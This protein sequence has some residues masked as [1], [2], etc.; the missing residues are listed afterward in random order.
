MSN[1]FV[2]VVLLSVMLSSAIF[3]SPPSV[4]ATSHEHPSTAMEQIER[5]GDKTTQSKMQTPFSWDRPGPVFA[6]IHLGS[7][8]AAG[9][10]EEPLR[11]IDQVIEQ[12]MRDHV[13]PGAVV[14]IVRRGIIVKH[15]AYGYAK[16]YEDDAFIESKQPIP[17]REDTI[18][19]VASISKLFTATAAMKLYE[20]GKILL[21]DPVAKYIPEF[22]QN[23]KE[24]VTIRQ[25]MTHTSG[26]AAW[27][28][29]YQMGANR[30]E[31]LQIVFAQPLEHPPGT[32]YTYSDLNMI[33]L[34]ALVE[35]LSGLRLDQFVYKYITKP[36]GM[37]DTMYNPSP[38]LKTRIAA[39]EYQPWTGRGLVWGEVHD[40][41]AWALDGVAGHAGVFS[42]AHDLAIFASM[43]LQN[44]K[45]GGK[46][47]LQPETVRLLTEN[48][49]PQF[50]GNDHGLGWELAQGWYMD[51]LSESTTLGHTGYTGTSI[52]VSPNNHVIAILLTNRVHPTR[53]TVS[54]NPLRR[55]I[56]RLTADAIPVAAP[57]KEQ[58]WFAG[59][60]DGLN[61]VLSA[62]V[63]LNAQATLTFDTWYRIEP[64][65]DFGVVEVSQDGIHWTQ[66]GELLTGSSGNWATKTVTIPAH[67]VSIRF[68][69]H[70]DA[71][72]NGRGWYVTNICLTDESGKKRKAIWE[73]SEWEQRSF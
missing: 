52:V 13:I 6:V 69:Y 49:I 11:K 59:Y 23:G 36:L 40:E 20:Q 61:A 63:S 42:T 38:Q 53:N 25:L 57:G 35:R 2:S 46:R 60:G 67:T 68:R 7:P 55:Q 58:A 72:V 17:M 50:P 65:A 19:D 32:T 27:I 28:P 51:A 29:L 66:A 21:D 31:R 45:Y 30:E 64:N 1:R 47:I 37:N 56:A 4:L 10:R 9:M 41:N 34:G 24:K 39:V 54:T 43:F 26:L 12:A 22:A 62:N 3:F 71:S 16:R 73:S 8:K 48:Q 14:Y 44:G 15:E 70:T 33:T 18:F 5:K